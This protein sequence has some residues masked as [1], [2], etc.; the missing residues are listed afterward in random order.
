[1]ARRKHIIETEAP[2]TYRIPEN[3]P[4]VPKFRCIVADPPWRR[5]QSS[6]DGRYG[7]AIN[8]YPLMSLERIKNMPVADLAADNA[9]LYLWVTN[10]NIDEGLEVI[11]AWGFR[12]I[13]VFHWIKPKIGVGNYFRN[14]SESVLFAVRGSLPPKCRTQINWMIDYPTEHSVKPR[15]FIS[16]VEK[17][18]PGPYLEL[19][20]RRRPASCEPWLCWGNETE[21]GADLF[22]QGYPVPKYSWEQNADE[23]DTPAADVATS[24]V[25]AAEV[26][27][28][29]AGATEATTAEATTPKEEA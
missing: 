11:K 18:S 8:H 24:E 7:G 5:N 4:E 13:T 19:F 14:A 6:G 21:G 3:I 2:S 25:T 10:S 12:F 16:I 26:T 15:S 23:G 20:C 1:M 17:V 9:H 27:A 28:T 29:G 22:I